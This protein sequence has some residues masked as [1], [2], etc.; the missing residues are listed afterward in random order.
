MEHMQIQLRH[1]TAS[2]WEEVNP[3][4]AR[5]ELGVEA[6]TFRAK[7]GD[8]ERAWRELPYLR[9]TGTEEAWVDWGNVIGSIEAN[10]VLRDT[11]AGLEEAIEA[12]ASRLGVEAAFEETAAALAT[13]ADSADVDAALADIKAALALKPDA[14]GVDDAL[15]GKAD[16]AAVDAALAKKA[17]TAETMVRSMFIGSIWAW[18]GPV[19]TIPTG[20]LLCNGAS[21][22]RTAYAALFAVIGTTYGYVGTSTF[23]LPDLRGEFLRG[24]DNGR[25]VDSKRTLGSVQGDAFQGH[26]HA[27]QVHVGVSTNAAGNRYGGGTS[28]TSIVKNSNLIA[29]EANEYQYGTQRVAAETR[30]RNVA[31]NY[32]IWAF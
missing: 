5:G 28:Y 21:L 1:D 18:A 2:A 20:A 19:S 3:V 4:L 11:L 9:G 27:V 29:Q 15:A 25:N 22:S 7:F 13:K 30:P 14:A 8:G 31:V 16:A 32:I 10:A 17:N 6:D 24:L 12:K 26:G 23:N